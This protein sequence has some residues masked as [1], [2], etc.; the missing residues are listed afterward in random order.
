MRNCP[1]CTSH[2]A[3][4]YMKTTA[5]N[6]RD[7]IE[8]KKCKN[9]QFIFSAASLCDYVFAGNIYAGM[10]R[11]ELL[12]RAQ[13]EG[14]PALCS[15]I[16]QKSRLQAGKVLDFGCGIGLT[17]L[18]LQEKSF[19]T[20]GI[21]T[22]AA[23]LTKHKELGITSAPS[24]EA[25]AMPK[26][27][28]DLVILKDV[29]E[30]VDNPINLLHNVVSYVKQGGYFYIRVP[31]VNHYNFHWSIDTKAH[32]NHFSP[33]KLMNLVTRNNLKKIDFIDVYDISTRA[34]KLYHSVFWKTRHFLP[35]YH[36][37]SLL[38]QKE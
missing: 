33:R 31:N 32:I 24:L 1:L 35:L 21:E 13:C 8:L 27:S 30:H 19:E 36:Q 16:I 7:G 5:W 14:L 11:Q 4:T 9:C 28:F 29:L 37:I 10:S 23:C 17:A 20:Y 22:S 6:N 38:Y 25:L 15:E 34:G 2:N 3:S 26:N 18:C 12:E